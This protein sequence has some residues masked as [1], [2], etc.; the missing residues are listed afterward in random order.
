[1]PRE[2]QIIALT[3][4]NPATFS[5]YV[6]NYFTS[7]LS[8][9]PP[10]IIAEIKAGLADSGVV[11]GV[12]LLSP[13]ASFVHSLF[14]LQTTY[15]EYDQGR[16]IKQT[17]ELAIAA[18]D[19]TINGA[20]GITLYLS[21]VADPAWPDDFYVFKYKQLDTIIDD[22]TVAGHQIVINV[23]FDFLLPAGWSFRFVEL[24]QGNAQPAVGRYGSVMY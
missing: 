17:F 11:G 20:S 23:T 6:T 16:E 8:T 15:G 12:D 9:L 18:A 22:L 4:I 19:G 3:K 24:S 13:S 21:D 14:A 1:M 5:T 2:E 10:E 7:V